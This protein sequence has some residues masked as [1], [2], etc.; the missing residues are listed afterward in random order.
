MNALSH[1]NIVVA[2]LRTLVITIQTYWQQSV[3]SK[4]IYMISRGHINIVSYHIVRM[5]CCRENVRTLDFISVLLCF[6]FLSCKRSFS[7]LQNP[8]KKKKMLG[9]FLF[10]RMTSPWLIS[11]RNQCLPFLIPVPFIIL[12][13]RS[14]EI[15]LLILFDISL[16]YHTSGIL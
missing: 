6:G 10:F 13:L 12:P 11:P 2:Y 1:P 8:K 7:L 4:Y 16:W 9:T 3:I 14:S 15:P 5:S